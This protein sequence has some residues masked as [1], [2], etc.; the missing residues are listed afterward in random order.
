MSD[1]AKSTATTLTV[2]WN[3]TINGDMKLLS[4]G[5]EGKGEKREKEKK[6]RD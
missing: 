2:K 6:R 5:E 1:L 3:A 4:R